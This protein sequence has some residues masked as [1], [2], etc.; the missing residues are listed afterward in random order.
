MGDA[1]A[2]IVGATRRD[3]NTV[4]VSSAMTDLLGADA[5]SRLARTC[6]DLDRP[7]ILLLDPG[8]RRALA[9][10]LRAGIRGLVSRPSATR[11]V[12]DSMRATTGQSASVSPSLTPPLLDWVSHVMPRTPAGEPPDLSS[13]SSRE[14]EVLGLLGQG[15][16]STQIARRLTIKETTARS[17]VHHILTKLGLRTRAE[18]I[19]AGLRSAECG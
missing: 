10:G 1:D 2:V 3:V 7:A 5:L 8:D 6:Q 17:H 15:L 16:S 9:E 18:A 4:I 11:E 14:E 13:L 12:A 19:V